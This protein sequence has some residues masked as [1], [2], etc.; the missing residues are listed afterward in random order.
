MGGV[1]SNSGPVTPISFEVL[2]VELWALDNE[3][4]SLS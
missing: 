2:T 1:S 3:N 4:E